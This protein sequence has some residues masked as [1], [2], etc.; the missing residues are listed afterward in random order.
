MASLRRLPNSV[1]WIACFTGADGRRFQRSTKIQYSHTSK[2]RRDA[3]QVADIYEDVA[4]KR[5]TVKQVQRVVAEIYKEM[6]GEGLPSSTFREYTKDWLARRKLELSPSSHAFYSNYLKKFVD[7]LGPDA[8]RPVTEIHSGFIRKFRDTEG[9]RVSANTVNHGLKS[10]RTIFNSIKNDGMIADNPADEVP[11]LK[12]EKVSSRRPFT[13]KEI[14]ILLD[15]AGPE[16]RSLI[17]FGLYTGQRLGD[18]ARLTWLNVDLEK[19]EIRLQTTKTGRQSILPIAPP[20]R[21]HLLTLPAGDDPSAYLHPKAAYLV[22]EKHRVG[23]LSRQFHDL[24]A[25]AGL[26]PPRPHRKSTKEADKDRRRNQ[27]GISFHALRHTITSMMKNSGVSPAI[28]EEFV[29]H[30]SKEMNRVYTHIEFES[31]KKAAEGLPDLS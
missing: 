26:V 1:F 2:S 13:I 30:D 7:F 23:A 14:Q 31:L 29:G 21:R 27:S 22:V 8:E 17:L 25:N 16:W 4:R 9:A 11:I 3:Q 19:D 6:T 5:K 15:Q 24:M 12:K 18:L 28:V 10:L 20:L